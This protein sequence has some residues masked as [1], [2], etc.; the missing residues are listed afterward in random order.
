MTHWFG[1]ATL[2]FAGAMVFVP[3]G[4][5]AQMMDGLAMG[6]TMWL[7]AGFWLL[8]AVALVLAVVALIKYLFRK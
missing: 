6:G 2:F 1:I 3:D 4:A 7:M 8:V 5:Q